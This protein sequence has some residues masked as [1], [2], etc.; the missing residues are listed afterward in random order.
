[1]RD[2]TNYAALKNTIIVLL[3]AF[4]TTNSFGQSKYAQRGVLDLRS[5]DFRAQGHASL[6]GEWELYMSQ[7]ISPETFLAK[8]NE[9]GDFV[10]FPSTWNETSRSLKPGKGYAT[11][12]LKV[13]VKKQQLAIAIPHFYTSFRLWV[14]AKPVAAN[15]EV[16]I[17]EKDSK[18]QW[19]PQTIPYTANQDTLDIV[20]HV[21]NFHHA[22]GGV[23]EDILLGAPSNLMLKRQIAVGSNLFLF[24]GLV[25]VALLFL[26]IFFLVKHD[27]SALF[28]AAL[29]FTW[30]V[31][32]LFSNLYV[33][34][35]FFPLFP[36][37]IAV[38]IEYITLY[39][40]MIWTV[41]FL[42]SLFP[43]DVNNMF[44]YFFVAFNA[45]F[46]LFALFT[47]ASLYTQFLPVYLSFCLILLL[48]VIY[49]LIHAVVYERNGVWLIVSCTLLGVIIFSYD[50][51]SYEGFA[52]FNPIIINIGYMGMFT[53][54]GLCLMYQLGLLK[55]SRRNRDMLT[56][57]D[58][59]GSQRKQ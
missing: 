2:C 48:Y 41:F 37:E 29:C 40:T 18:P 34:T 35:S 53:L 10:S 13:L 38:K 12:H 8:T 22:K 51:I 45:I 52:S 39:L 47:S 19:L 57:D 23:R 33:G 1:L 30:A 7:L 5:V 26:F 46:V 24:G 21:S 25:L 4:I 15:G 27:R 28:F 44:K 32:S 54:M 50:L 42:A 58:L 6:S 14:N 11:Y 31:R 20:I 56:Y 36:W 55:R 17:T 16:G 59:Y 49:V 43:Q 3:L 9:P